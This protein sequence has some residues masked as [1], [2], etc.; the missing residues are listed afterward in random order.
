[1]QYKE[2]GMSGF[3]VKRVNVVGAF[4]SLWAFIFAFFPFY[5][6]EPMEVLIQQAGKQAES[7]ALTKN[8]V[9][10]NFFG[11]LCL[12]LSIVAF[13]LYIWNSSQLVRAAAIIVSVV[14]FISLMLALIVG[15]SNIKDIKSIITY[16]VQYSGSGMKTSM[17]VKT[18]VAYGFVLELIM[19]LIMIGSYWINEMLFRPY[20]LG[21]K[22][23]AVLNP[24]EGLV[25]TAKASYTKQMAAHM[26][27]KNTVSSERP[28]QSSETHDEKI[29]KTLKKLLTKLHCDDNIIKSLVRHNKIAMERYRSGHNG[30]VLKTV[31]LHGRM[32]SN[33][34]LSA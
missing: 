21:N 6:I 13:G 34:I 1:M 30:A 14:D 11:V 26:H 29:K 32:G 17:F 31:C 22:S 23:E 4:A 19:V 33:P 16:A 27:M 28:E 3:S 9:S 15:N 10:Y 24:L 8:L 2:T 7:Y 18:S 12:M 25:G 20:V 5:R